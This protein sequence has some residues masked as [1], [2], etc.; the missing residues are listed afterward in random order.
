MIETQHL[1]HPV[2]GKVTTPMAPSA[3]DKSTATKIGLVGGAASGVA[4]GVAVGAATAGPVGAAVGGVIGAVAGAAGGKALVDTIGPAADDDVYWA[5][6]HVREPYY[7]PGT[8]YEYYRPAFEHGWLGVERY[9]GTYVEAESR[10]AEDWLRSPG[11]NMAW[12]DA[13]P[14]VQGTP[15]SGLRRA[16]PRVPSKG[17][18]STPTS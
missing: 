3:D 11:R 13:R 14:A 18:P 12:D 2:D 17:S 10:L 9:P 8:P 6:A 1:P 5:D 7:R 15:G 16:A 4:T